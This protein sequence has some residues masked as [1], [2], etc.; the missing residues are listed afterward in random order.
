MLR[1]LDIQDNMENLNHVINDV[2]TR[3]TK[4]QDKNG[5]I[6]DMAFELF[7]W[8]TE[9]KRN[10]VILHYINDFTV[11]KSTDGLRTLNEQKITLQVELSK[12]TKWAKK[13]LIYLLLFLYTYLQ[14]KF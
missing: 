12:V 7:R 1:P 5:E 13:I 6:P 2:M 11:I 9:C 10:N 14:R 4:V 3:M 8:S